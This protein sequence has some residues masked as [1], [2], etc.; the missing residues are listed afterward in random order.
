M[1]VRILLISGAVASGKSTLSSGLALRFNARVLKTKGLIQARFPEAISERSELQRLGDELDRKTKFNWVR[2]EVTKD[3]RERGFSASL[4]VVDAV[5]KVEQVD[6]IRRA[7]G[8]KVF[9]I[10]LSAATEELSRRYVG[11]KGSL[12]KE[13]PD[14]ASVRSGSTTEQ[15]ISR[16]ENIADVVI[17]TD[18]CEPGDVLIRAASHLGL[19]GREQER[20]VDVIVGGQFGSEG[21][22]HICSYLAS[23]YE[24]LVRVGGPNA[25]HKVFQLPEPYTHRQLP[26]GTLFSDAKLLIGPGAVIDP[27]TLLREAADCDVDAQRL[28]IDP[29]AM[30]ITRA[31]KEA[32][33]ALKKQIGSTG[34]GV[35][36]AAARRILERGLSVHTLARDVPQ[37][38]PFCRPVAFELEEAYRKRSRILLEGTQGTGLSVF[39]GS[40]PHVTS[41]DTTV[42]GCLSEAGIPPIRV[43]RVIM[44]C[45]SYVIRVQSPPGSTSGPMKLELDWSIVS[46]RAKLPLEALK[47]LELGSVSGNQ[48]R[49]GEFDWELLRRAS[50]L[51]APTDIAL[52]FADYVDSK[53]TDARRFEQLTPATIRF[54]E[55]IEKVASA[56]VSLISTRFHW[57]SIIDRRAW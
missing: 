26:S 37:L 55:E 11:R 53:N 56:P 43:R 4:V 12:D 45:R 42:P 34:Q 41:R 29:Q 19:Y 7:Y 32:E 46:E 15:R 30:V 36:N 23:E 54:A 21:K 33:A 16:L 13:L 52:T 2:D 24:V 5:R 44:V 40:Y 10:H 51:N 18:R 14:Y 35:G 9:H 31:D 48:R 50:L 39:H 38:R 57:K 8:P 1:D 20:L 22:G 6:S 28:A 49:V 25:G 3:V 27:E 17:A 47:G